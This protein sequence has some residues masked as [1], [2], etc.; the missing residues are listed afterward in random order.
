MSGRN[1]IHRIG[2]AP[3]RDYTKVANGLI[4]HGAAQLGPDAFT[5]LLLLLSHTDG[6]E[7]SAVEIS[8][9]LL[10]GKNQRRARAALASLVI[11]SRLVIREYQRDGG[12]VVKREYVFF[13]DGRQFTAE[14][15]EK[16][17]Q[18]IIVAGRGVNQNG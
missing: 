2:S 15:V 11:H 7:T 4:R 5:V 10:W 18:P 16:Y 8:R 3:G 6:W 13:A 9:Q 12:G 14:E 1:P 17:S